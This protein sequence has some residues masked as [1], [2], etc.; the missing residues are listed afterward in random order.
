MLFSTHLH[1]FTLVMFKKKKEKTN[2]SWWRHIISS[3]KV[4][5]SCVALDGH[6]ANVTTS[7]S[8]PSSSEG[9]LIFSTASSFSPVDISHNASSTQ[10]CLP[11]Q[12]SSSSSSSSYESLRTTAVIVPEAADKDVDSVRI[13]R[14]PAVLMQADTRVQPRNLLRQLLHVLRSKRMRQIGQGEGQGHT[15]IHSAVEHLNIRQLGFPNIGNSCYMNATLQC[16]LSISCFWRPIRAQSSCLTDPSSCQMLRCFSD[17]QQA[18]LTTRSTKQKV[19]L[20]GALLECVSARCPAFEEDYEQDAHEFLMLCLLQLKEEGERLRASFFSYICPVA[21]FEFHIK[22][23]LTCTSCGKQSCRVDVYN[24]LSVNLSPATTD[25]LHTYFKPTLLERFCECE[26]GCEATE[27]VEFFTLPRIFVLHL[28]R[29]DML[30]QKLSD[31]MDVPSELDL[32]A[33]P[34]VASLRQQSRNVHPLAPT[35]SR[36][37]F[38]I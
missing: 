15:P 5:D 13:E 12:A 30:G 20:L 34:G 14:F 33:L 4:S 11:G 36:R 1:R 38:L 35:D 8:C 37:W 28:K 10:S 22:S 32:S 24:H 21:N 27:E 31:V 23:V 9:S 25:S 26:A 3:S 29:F 19:Q 7:T 17:L 2:R 16:L 18:Q 6:A